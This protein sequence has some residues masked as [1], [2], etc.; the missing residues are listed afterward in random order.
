MFLF[1]ES[2]NHKYYLYKIDFNKVS[3]L[4]LLFTY[5]IIKFI[6][7]VKKTRSFFP[8][9]TLKLKLI[10]LSQ[11]GHPS[12]FTLILFKISYNVSNHDFLNKIKL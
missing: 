6:S 3:C 1:S 10:R 9:S 12:K 7:S 2:L 4:G 11:I 5:L 8:N